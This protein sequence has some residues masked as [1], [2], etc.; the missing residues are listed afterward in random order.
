[1]ALGG[2]IGNG[3]GTVTMGVTAD[4]PVFAPLETHCKAGTLP[5]VGH[6]EVTKTAARCFFSSCKVR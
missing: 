5:V 6:L 4:V 1:M 2:V 3:V